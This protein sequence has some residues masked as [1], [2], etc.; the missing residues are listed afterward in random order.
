MMNS[1]IMAN[2][3]NS[4][5]DSQD[6]AQ[7]MRNVSVVVYIILFSIA[8]AVPFLVMFFKKHGNK[9]ITPETFSDNGQY[10]LSDPNLRGNFVSIRR[11]YDEI[12]FVAGEYTKNAYITIVN[13][14]N[15]GKHKSYL[16]N[17]SEG[18]TVRIPCEGD[19][20]T[21]IP[22]SINGKKIPG[23]YKV[24]PSPET[25]FLCS[26]LPA[27]L[28]TLCCLYETVTMGFDLSTEKFEAFD[29]GIFFFYS[30]FP[31]LIGFPII[32]FL[33][34]YHSSMTKK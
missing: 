25:N 19:A 15:H 27:V 23:P 17:F 31:I 11:E 28:V 10:I 9:E 21:I 3:T 4:L 22:E 14:S 26:F 5:D 34:V 7:S 30:F 20:L 24:N 32:M 16:M 33:L 1:L 2:V 13:F 6:F 8:I 18:R 12:V 29:C